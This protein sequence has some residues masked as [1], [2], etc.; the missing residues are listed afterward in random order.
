MQYLSSRIELQDEYGN[1]DLEK[2]YQSMASLPMV[3]QYLPKEY[4]VYR[5]DTHYCIDAATEQKLQKQRTFT[6]TFASPLLVYAGVKL[7]G[8]MGTAVT[9]L[10]IACGLTHYAQHKAV[11]NA[12]YRS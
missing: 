6:Y 7:G 12:P 8:K 11:K 5:T 3:N 9:L 2:V 4:D 10:G 1:L